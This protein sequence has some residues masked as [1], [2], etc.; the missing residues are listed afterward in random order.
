[1]EIFRDFRFDDFDIR[2]QPSTALCSQLQSCEEKLSLAISA[3]VINVEAPFAKHFLCGEK[4]LQKSSVER[5]KPKTITIW[6]TSSCPSL[7]V[8]QLL[9]W[10]C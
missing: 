6:T 9:P 4:L 7:Q 1:M 8:Y 5:F 2:V 10:E 3:K